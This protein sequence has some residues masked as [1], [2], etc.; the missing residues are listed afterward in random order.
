MST[1]LPDFDRLFEDHTDN[2]PFPWQRKLYGELVQKQ[3]RTK[4][5]VPTGLGKTSVIALDSPADWSMW[6]I[7]ELLW[8]R[9]SERQKMCEIHSIKYCILLFDT[10]ER[11]YDPGTPT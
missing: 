9:L 1:A 5:D 8:I 3:F 7:E 11:L 10:N 2:E 4:C 6:R